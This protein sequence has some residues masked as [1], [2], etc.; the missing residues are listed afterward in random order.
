MLDRQIGST[1]TTTTSAQDPGVGVKRRMFAGFRP[2]SGFGLLRMRSSQNRSISL[3]ESK[4]LNSFFYLFLFLYQKKK[5]TLH[6]NY[7]MFEI[8][9]NF[10]HKFLFCFVCWNFWFDSFN[11]LQ[12]KNKLL[13]NFFTIFLLLFCKSF[14]FLSQFFLLLFIGYDKFEEQNVAVFDVCT[15]EIL[16][17]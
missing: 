6:T 13:S 16:S 5:N 2:L 1:A 3:P 15:N 17:K 11:Y 8:F 9:P 7:E 4:F 10:V 14:I 12:Q